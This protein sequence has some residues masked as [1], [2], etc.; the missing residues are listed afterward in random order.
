MVDEIAAANAKSL[1]LD[2]DW[3]ASVL[4][5]RL[6]HY[7]G[8]TGEEDGV[9]ALEP[10]DL[11]QHQSTYAEFVLHYELSIEERLIVLLSIVPHIRPQLLDPLMIKNADLDRNF[12]EFGGV[13]GR[14]HAG[15]LPTG[16][17]ALFL[18]AGDDL[19]K[20][21]QVRHL[22]DSTHFFSSHGILGFRSAGASEPASSGQLQLTTE[23]LDYFTSGRPTPPAFSEDFPAKKI[24]SRESWDDLVLKNQ[25]ME[26]IQELNAWFRHG[27]A[28]MKD[29]G[30][31]RCMRPGYRSLFYG[32]PGT[33]KTMT[34]ALLASEAGRDIYRVD[35]SA[36]V[37]KWVG[38]TSKN[39]AK[40]FDQAQNRNWIL[41]FDEADA[42]FTKRTQLKDAHDKYANQEVAFLLQRLE[43]FDGVVILATNL[44]EQLD[45]AFT[46]R[47]DSIIHFPMPSKQE[48]LRIWENSVEGRIELQDSVDL[49]EIAA[50]YDLSGGAIMNIV[51]FASLMALDDGSRIISLA[52]IERGVRQEL[53]K[54]S[55]S[56]SP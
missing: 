26:R 3:F 16:E 11:S 12:T 45:D 43:D 53:Q 1:A 49:P 44:R 33:G 2:L 46:R 51:R 31:E 35:L 17:T 47:F 38:E 42:L 14:N 22:M 34:A 8:N 28:L 6:R 5:T 21:M 37:S 54:E 18:L 19:G 27:E 39:L 32:P 56:Q 52:N 48:R 30:F 7:F 24:V 4:N 36:V 13:Q 29:L 9:F 23:Y 50:K 10:P 25:V 20:R 40:V 41:F 15:F 55:R